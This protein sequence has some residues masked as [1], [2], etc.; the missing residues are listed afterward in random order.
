MTRDHFKQT[1]Y[2][3]NFQSEN[4]YNESI[5]GKFEKKIFNFLKSLNIFKRKK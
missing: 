2:S 5:G 4:Y 3:P 1:I